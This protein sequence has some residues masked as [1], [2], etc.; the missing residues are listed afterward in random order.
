[1]SQSSRIRLSAKR[2]TDVLQCNHEKD[3]VFVIGSQRYPCPSFLAEFLSERVTASRFHDPT[4][5][6]FHINVDPDH[7]IPQESFA[8]FIRLGSGE[9]ISIDSSNRTHIV[10][11]CRSVGNSELSELILSGLEVSS[12]SNPFVMAFERFCVKL[13]FEIDASDEINFLALNFYRLSVDLLQKMSIAQLSSILSKES[14]K[15][16]NEDSLCEF[17]SSGLDSASEFISLLEFVRF[18]FVTAVMLGS[19]CEKLGKFL[20]RLTPSLWSSIWHRLMDNA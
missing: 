19:L 5:D 17:I 12:K 13:E 11:I 15:L 2:M 8:D 9:E 6:S 3:F 7:P 4:L 10:S 1:M 16:L 18:E 20:D 14:V